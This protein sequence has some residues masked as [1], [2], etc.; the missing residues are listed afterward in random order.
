MPWGD[1]AEHRAEFK[2]LRKWIA[3]L[4]L[5][6]KS[7]YFRDRFYFF[8][9]WEWTTLAPIHM[10][11]FV[12]ICLHINLSFYR[13]HIDLIFWSEIAW[14]FKTFI[15]HKLMALMGSSRTVRPKLAL[16]WLVRK[17]HTF[18]V[19]LELP[20]ISETRLCVVFNII[21]FIFVE[22]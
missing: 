12:G 14:K 9:H 6:W 7:Y 1:K 3:T 11:F 16:K 19:P 20:W 21:Q 18:R 5:Y 8:L 22:I 13:S 17:I 15:L 2:S 10:D 4:Q